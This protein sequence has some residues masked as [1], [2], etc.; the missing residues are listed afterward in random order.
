MQRTALAERLGE[1]YQWWIKKKPQ[2][3]DLHNRGLDL[4]LPALEK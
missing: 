1:S 4:P 2:G 3:M